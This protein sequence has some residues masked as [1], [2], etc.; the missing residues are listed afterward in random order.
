MAY[1]ITETTGNSE[2][3]Y[4]TCTYILNDD[5]KVMPQV[6]LVKNYLITDNLKDIKKLDKLKDIQTWTNIYLASQNK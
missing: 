1:V 5:M 2:G 4:Y 3:N 6:N